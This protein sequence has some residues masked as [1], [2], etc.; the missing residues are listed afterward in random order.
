MKTS[1]YFLLLYGL[2]R[3]SLP[4]AA[5]ANRPG[6]YLVCVSNERG[7]SV[8][9]ID[10]TSQLTLATIP[11]GK[12]PRGIHAAPDGKTLFV[13]V[14]GTP[15]SGPPAL[16]K[17]GN[18]ILKK[19]GDDDDD[20][21]K[22][23]HS[24]DGIAVVD[25]ASRKFVKK[26]KAGSDPEQFA[27][28]HDGTRIYIAN[29][30]V[31]TASV[32]N[33]ASEKVEAIAR[34]KK[35]PEGVALAPDG[36]F[37]YVTCETGGEV[38]VLDSASFKPIADF[39]LGGRPRSVAFLPDGTRAY[40]PSESSGQLHVCDPVAHKKLK[41]IQLPPGSRPMG[42]AMAK[43]GKQLCVSTGR[44]GTVLIFDTKTETVTA[45]IKVG[46]RPWGLALSPD[47]SQLFVANGP[48]N[49]ISVVDLGGKKEIT[50]IKCG[51][52]PW[53]VEVVPVNATL[54]KDLQ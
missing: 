31:A 51:E 6:N 45:T 43:D 18:P 4:D 15:I 54:A 32:L 16:D 17:N 29:E 19:G 41:T 9:I 1:F 22:S 25:L 7:G 10:G 27:I 39:T 26:L 30:D 34:V 11:I 38:F 35:E 23:D 44:G 48:S 36:R 2:S 50:R 3:A 40:I 33:V 21:A 8:T 47:G 42:T 13:A 28:S 24:A 49:D 46:A 53:G 5:A 20:D 14:S 37:V 52:G 12:R